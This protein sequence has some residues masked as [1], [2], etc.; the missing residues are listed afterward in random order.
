MDRLEGIAAKKILD[1]LRVDG[2]MSV[3]EIADKCSLTSDEVESGIRM[4][5]DA[6]AITYLGYS[7]NELPGR[8][9]DVGSAG[10]PVLSGKLLIPVEFEQ[11]SYEACRVG[12]ELASKIGAHPVLLH[13]YAVPSL[14]DT[15]AAQ[16]NSSDDS[17]DYVETIEEVEVTKIQRRNAEKKMEQFVK[18]IS[19]MVRAGFIPDIRFSTEVRPG[20]PEEGILEFSRVESPRLIVMATRSFG[21]KKEEMIGSVTAEVLDGCR[22]PLL[23]IPEGYSYHGIDNMRRIAFFCSLENRDM[24]SM[25]IFMDT[26]SQSDLEVT[27]IPSVDKN[28]IGMRLNAL[29]NYFKENYPHV[30]FETKMFM[31]PDFKQEIDGFMARKDIQMYVVPNKK[32]N[33]FRRLFKPGIAHRIL[34]EKDI[35]LLALPV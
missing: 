30:S 27:L 11:R 10:V 13:V 25:K 24:T 1:A 33:I 28:D 17:P 23:T 4:L 7:I 34:F 31:G 9:H 8:S 16:I 12:L 3:A 32:M 21:R 35:P 29:L 5:R 18:G 15:Y 19:D 6:G 20:V 22:V 14:L 2:R 26:M